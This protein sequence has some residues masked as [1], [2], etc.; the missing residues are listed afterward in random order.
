MN[1]LFQ[2][3]IPKRSVHCFHQGEHLLPG[4]EIYS[5]L[6]EDE[7]QQLVRRD[8]CTACWGEVSGIEEKKATQGYWK[9]KIELRKVA[10]E[11][12]RVG[13]ALNLLREL[14]QAP[15]PCEGEIF[16]LCLF[17]ARA[18]QIV[19]RQEFKKESIAYQLY[20]ILHKEEYVTIKVVDLSQMQ[21]ENIQAALADRL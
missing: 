20:E 11:S 8:F 16:I 7:S 5:L 19:L 2:I 12:S 18:R 14:R 4:M 3:E 1:S 13:R 6:L 21:I 15:E 10:P 9:S 17:L